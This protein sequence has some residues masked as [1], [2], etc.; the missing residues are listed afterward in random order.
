MTYRFTTSPPEIHDLAH[1]LDTKL[2]Y[3]L[4]DARGYIDHWIVPRGDE[5]GMIATYCD[6]A[7][8][9]S[10]AMKAHA[11]KVFEVLVATGAELRRVSAYF[12]EN[13]Y[14]IA[15][16]LDTMYDRHVFTPHGGR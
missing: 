16:G 5:D 13:E 4:E 7:R 15:R 9:L 11:L 3:D 12:A 14:E 1:R 2:A 6:T 8:G 10:D